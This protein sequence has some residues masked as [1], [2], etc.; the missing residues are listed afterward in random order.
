LTFAY[1][2]VGPNG[3]G[4]A[5]LNGATFSYYMVSASQV[6]FI[7]IGNPAASVTSGVATL[8]SSGGFSSTS[9]G[10]NSLAV[11]NGTSTAGPIA[12]AAS[13]FS[14]PDPNQITGTFGAGGTGVLNQNNSGNVSA[15]GFSGTYSVAASGRGTATLST[16][17]TYV[18]YLIGVN[19]AVIQETDNSIVSDGT[20]VGLAGG[21]FSTSNLAGGYALQLSGVAAGHGEQDVLG[22]IN[23]TTGQLAT[24]TVDVN[25]ANSAGA[26][27]AFTPAPG[28]AIPGGTSYMIS[29]GQGPFN[30]TVAG[31]NLQFA[32]YFLS[33]SSVF[34][35][36]TDMADTRVL[37]G[38]LF[39]DVS[40]SPAIV[41]ATS[42]S[43]GVGVQGTFTVIATGNPA[44]T[45]SETGT[46]PSGVTFNALT[47]VLSGTPAA[48][49]GGTSNTSYPIQFTASNGV[50]ST[51][52]QNFTLTV[53]YCVTQG[54]GTC[55]PN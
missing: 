33:S 44:P 8:Q 31:T 42:T 26:L 53:V 10:G 40:L 24:G 51:A 9:L 34:L 41:S 50:G 49:T 16:G 23:T 48:G 43:F 14:Q 6:Q 19:R 36:R 52:V 25:T 47:G 38:S 3:R 32:A 17:Q 27:T 5:T 46:L 55:T 29:N 12:T 45:L 39:Q 11:T 21:P 28:V 18:F 2:F 37:H 7:A 13:F 54:N 1:Q 15:A 4:L 20:L 35:L 22:Q 30:V